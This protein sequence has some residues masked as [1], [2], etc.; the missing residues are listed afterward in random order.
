[1]ANNDEMSKYD[2]NTSYEEAAILGGGALA[3]QQYSKHKSKKYDTSKA[4]NDSMR[5]K[6]NKWKISEE[7]LLAAKAHIKI[8]K[9]NLKDMQAGDNNKK[10]ISKAKRDLKSAEKKVDTILE[11]QQI[12]KRLDINPDKAYDDVIRAHESEKV[13]F[14]TDAGKRTKNHVWF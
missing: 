1:M 4:D 2:D 3:A 12:K 5:S 8:A 13:Y 14:E 11:Q 6:A 7:D 10:A 9:T